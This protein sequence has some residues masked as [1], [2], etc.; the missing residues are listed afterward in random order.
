[1]YPCKQ[2]HL[3]AKQPIVLFT[4][5]KKVF[6][7]QMHIFMLRCSFAGCHLFKQ[8][9]HRLLFIYLLLFW[10]VHVLLRSDYQFSVFLVA[11]LL[12]AVSLPRIP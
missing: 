10:R 1:M 7:L 4:L 3:T 8:L 2:D 12:Q 9:L 6:V 5:I 11:D